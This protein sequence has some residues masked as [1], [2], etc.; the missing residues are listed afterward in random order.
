M[1][2]GRRSGAGIGSAAAKSTEPRL[3]LLRLPLTPREGRAAAHL[4][5]PPLKDASALPQETGQV[6]LRVLGGDEYND[7]AEVLAAGF[8]TPAVII[9]SLCTPA[10]LD[11]QGITA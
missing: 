6:R 11:A 8:G 10:V 7:F 5:C 2:A 1:T 9:S 3:Q 4:S